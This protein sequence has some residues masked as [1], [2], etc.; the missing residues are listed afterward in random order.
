MSMPYSRV[1]WDFDSVET[2]ISRINKKKFSN[3]NFS[4]KSWSHRIFI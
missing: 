1:Q 2:E 4:T 3:H